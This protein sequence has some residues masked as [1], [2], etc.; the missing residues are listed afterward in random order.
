MGSHRQG[1]WPVP[2]SC[3]HKL[4]LVVSLSFFLFCLLSIR[5]IGQGLKI[6]EVAH[7]IQKSVS[8][9]ISTK[10]KMVNSYDTWHGNTFSLVFIYC[11]AVMY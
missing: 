7:D 6:V 5:Y 3:C 1:N 4:L 11:N 9:Y 2:R 8:S 10:L